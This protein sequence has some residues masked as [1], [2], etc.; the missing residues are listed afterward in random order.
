[1]TLATLSR[2]ATFTFIAAISL[3]PAAGQAPF[4]PAIRATHSDLPDEW[5]RNAWRQNGIGDDTRT[6]PRANGGG[7]AGNARPDAGGASADTGDKP[8][9]AGHAR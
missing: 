5:Q 2:V 6:R 8:A 4:S 1:M 9:N 3:A 7:M